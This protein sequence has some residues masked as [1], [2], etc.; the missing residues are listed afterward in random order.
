[1]PDR[2]ATLERISEE[3][4]LDDDIMDFL[5]INDL[6]PG[7]KVEV[8]ART[9]DGVITVRVNDSAQVGLSTFIAER[10]YVAA[11]GGPF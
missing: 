9:P 11:S 10:V 1:M 4:E 6:R 3:L 7:A 8:A 5:D 2:V